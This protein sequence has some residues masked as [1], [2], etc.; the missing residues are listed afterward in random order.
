MKYILLLIIFSGFVFSNSSAQKQEYQSVKIGNQVWMTKNLDIDKFRNGDPIPQAKTQKEW[1]NAF[2]NKQAAWCYYEHSTTNGKIYGKLYNWYAV[3]DPRGLAP[4]GWH[5]PSWQEFL[6][7]TK[8]YDKDPDHPFSFLKSTTGWSYL[9]GTNTTGFTALP[10]GYRYYDEYSDYFQGKGEQAYWWSSTENEDE[11]GSSTAHLLSLYNDGNFAYG[12]LSKG[13]GLSVRCMKGN[14][15]K[16]SVQDIKDA[17]IYDE[18]IDEKDYT[19]CYEWIK[20]SIEKNTTDTTYSSID[21]IK[22]YDYEGEYGFTIRMSKSGY[23]G[24]PWILFKTY[25][26]GECIEENNKVIIVFTD[27]S[28]IETTSNTKNNCKNN[29]WLRVDSK[30]FR[31]IR[32]KIVDKVQVYTKDGFV[33]QSFTKKQSDAFRATFTHLVDLC[34]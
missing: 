17:E 5:I 29:C 30:Y 34:E 27:K 15:S 28:K 21:D 25:G 9:K 33:E 32:Y 4:E 7:L 14:S 6:I 26:S 11:F 8:E 19:N 1:A 24:L 31:D 16:T 13:S 20:S 12:P 2:N 22:I 10:G 23:N 3:N 18:T